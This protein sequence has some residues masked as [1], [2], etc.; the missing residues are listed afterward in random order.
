MKVNKII[1]E[2]FSIP[3][4]KTGTIK[5]GNDY[6]RAGQVDIEKFD[7]IDNEIF[8]KTLK[9]SRFEN[10][11][12]GAHYAF[13]MDEYNQEYFICISNLEKLLT[14]TEIPFIPGIGWQAFWAFEV[15]HNK[16]TLFVI[17]PKAKIIYKDAKNK[18]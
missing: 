11:R 2:K 9:F 4:R 5:T 8:E 15:K 10:I 6:Y 16:V 13:L 18:K 17:P 7:L 1:V 12:N 14:E 3:I